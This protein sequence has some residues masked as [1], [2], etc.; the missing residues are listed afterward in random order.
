[1]HSSQLSEE[2]FK[3]A[4]QEAL[5]EG[6]LWWQ[7]RALVELGWTDQRRALIL[8]HADEIR[9]SGQ[10]LLLRELAWAEGDERVYVAVRKEMA[11]TDGW[12]TVP[13]LPGDAA[14]ET[15]DPGSVDD[16]VDGED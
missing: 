5:G 15:G 3:L 8:S 11:A 14:N 10:L 16:S 9:A 1:M 13:V 2:L 6:D 4:Y 7:L 12:W